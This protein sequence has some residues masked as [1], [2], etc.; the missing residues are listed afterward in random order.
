MLASLS[1]NRFGLSSMSGS[2]CQLHPG[3]VCFTS[4]FRKK[5]RVKS[6]LGSNALVCLMDSQNSSQMQISANIFFKMPSKYNTRFRDDIAR[7]LFTSL[8][9][10]TSKIL[11]SPYYH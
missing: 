3:A 4:F 1:I 6:V 8:L 9:L 10:V 11:R 5:N 2:F 7:K